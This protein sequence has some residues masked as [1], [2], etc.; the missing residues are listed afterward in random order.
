MQ[1]SFLGGTLFFHIVFI[2]Y[3]YNKFPIGIEFFV[4]PYNIITRMITSATNP[5]MNAQ[6]Q[7]A[8]NLAN[9]YAAIYRVPQEDLLSAALEGLAI[10]HNKFNPNKNAQFGTYAYDWMINRIMYAISQESKV[11]RLSENIQRNIKDIKRFCHQYEARYGETPD[12]ETI[13]N[14]LDL[15]VSQ[16]IDAFEFGNLN[17]Y[18]EEIVGKNA[19]N[20]SLEFL[21]NNDDTKDPFAT[22]LNGLTD[23][24]SDIICRYFG[25]YSDAQTDKEIGEVYGLSHTA[26]N[27]RRQRALRKIQSHLSKS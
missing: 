8:E 7:V 5:I 18:I 26:I 20:D 10:A 24:E 12:Y 3:F 11:V 14:A 23:M 21:G 2:I 17:C 15:R 22:Y 6:M 16:V 4:K 9:K 19:D 27:T 13:A 25:V 1:K